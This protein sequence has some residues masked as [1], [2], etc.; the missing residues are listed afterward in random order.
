MINKYNWHSKKGDDHPNK[1]RPFICY[2]YLP[3]L[4]ERLNSGQRKGSKKKDWSQSRDLSHPHFWFWSCWRD[5]PGTACRSSW[6][7][8]R[9]RRA[10]PPRGTRSR[11][12]GSCDATSRA[13]GGSQSVMAISPVST[14]ISCNQDK[15]YLRLRQW[16]YFCNISWFQQIFAVSCLV[17]VPHLRHFV[18]HRFQSSAVNKANQLTRTPRLSSRQAILSVA[19]HK[20]GR[21]SRKPGMW[22]NIPGRI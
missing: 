17:F 20:A 14:V 5:L 8:W 21:N 22:R 15:Y 11:P 18:K 9:R 10:G 4:T 7:R 13:T 3:I 12:G 19:H 16:W 2:H 1:N 6:R